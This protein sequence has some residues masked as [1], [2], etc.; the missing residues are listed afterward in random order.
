[1]SLITNDIIKLLNKAL[2]QT[3]KQTSE[4]EITYVCPFHVA[5]NNI[6]RRK[7]GIDLGTQEFNCFACGAKGKSFKSLFK[8][9]GL[10][11]EYFIELN[12]IIKEERSCFDK[13]DTKHFNLFVSKDIKTTTYSLP[14]EFISLTS[15]V[16]DTKDITYKH[17]MSY[18]KKRN[19]TIV[20]IL[21]YNIGYCA[22]GKYANR[23]IF[24]SYNSDGTLNFFTGRDFTGNSSLRYLNCNFDK[25]IIGFES[26]INFHDELTIVEGPIDAIAIRRNCIPLFGKFM[27]NKLKIKLI[28]NKPSIVN[29]LL[30]SDALNH[31]YEISDFLTTNGIKTKIIKLFDGKDSSECGFEKTW[32][33][34]D[35]CGILT[36]SE[37]FK[38]KLGFKI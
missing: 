23:I 19:I 9:L 10:S 34:I 26:L 17:A 32:S 20:D 15:D 36:N 18:L 14:K 12:R 6:D 4:S 35:R 22:D 8:K 7:F 16:L 11:K 21:R 25:N 13:V 24:P 37:I 2:K 30:D 28:E 3:G 29:V 5:R 31:S 33:I 27:S 38:Y 1:M